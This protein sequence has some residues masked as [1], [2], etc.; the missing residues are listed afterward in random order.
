MNKAIVPHHRPASP[1][2]LSPSASPKI[3]KIG[4]TTYD[5]DVRGFPCAMV[6]PTTPQ[7]S[8]GVAFAPRRPLL[9]W[10]YQE[11]GPERQHILLPFLGGKDL[12]RLSECCKGLMNYR[13]FLPAIKVGLKKCYSQPVPPGLLHLLSQQAALSYLRAEDKRTVD[14]VM[15]SLK[16]RAG[17]HLQG[18][19]LLSGI[20]GNVLGQHQ[21]EAIGKILAEGGC[22]RLEELRVALTA[23]SLESGGAVIMAALK[24]GACSGIHRLCLRVDGYLAGDMVASTLTAHHLRGLQVNT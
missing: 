1:S 14:L 3:S 2:P 11:M 9:D 5:D 12:L 18:L 7:Q 8:G 24:N 13:L 6:L 4:S 20:G 21:A 10:L 22:P 16:A 19:D 17:K 23:E 15:E